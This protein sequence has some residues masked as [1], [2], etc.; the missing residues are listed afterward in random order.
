M[1]PHLKKRRI[2]PTINATPTTPPIVPA[3]IAFLFTF[4]PPLLAA[5]AVA[6]ALDCAEEVFA[7]KLADVDEDEIEGAM[8]CTVGVKTCP[9]CSKYVVSA[10]RTSYVEM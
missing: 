3:I 6:L 8:V 7:I 9:I 10:A 4:D 5:A 2:N 1:F